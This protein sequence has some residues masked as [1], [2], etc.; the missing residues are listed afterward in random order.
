M[1]NWKG[2][3]PCFAVSELSC[4][5]CGQLKLDLVFAMALVSLRYAWGSPLYLNSVCRCSEHNDDVD[6]HPNSLHQTENPVH[7]T[8][9]TAA[10]DVNWGTWPKEV[11]FK[12]AQLAWSLGWSLGLAQTFMHLDARAFLPTLTLDQKIF[13]YDNWTYIFSDVDIKGDSK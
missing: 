2:E 8:D 1:S 13:H 6:G 5:H 7:A 3:L 9:G 12:F 4:H 11:K 10:V